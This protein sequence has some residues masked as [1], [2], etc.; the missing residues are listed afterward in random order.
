[1]R[2][3]SNPVF[4]CIFDSDG[5]WITEGL[6]LAFMSKEVYNYEKK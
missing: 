3:S 1:M 5:S 2:G 4:I 6:L